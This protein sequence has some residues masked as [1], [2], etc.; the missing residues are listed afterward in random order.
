MG[1]RPIEV[2]P[3]H[4]FLGITFDKKLTF[5]KHVDEL[6]ERCM[7]AMSILKVVSHQ[8]WGADRATKLRL[9]RALIRSKLDYGSIVYGGACES[10]LRRL[11]VVQNTA[12]H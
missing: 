12:F 1:G 9:W 5:K 7:K 6:K 3:Y 4:K 8:K 11:N 10:D 2:V